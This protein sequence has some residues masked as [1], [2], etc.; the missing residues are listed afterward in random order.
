[1]QIFLTFFKNQ[2]LATLMS[3]QCIQS[4]ALLYAKRLEKVLFL[5]LG[6]E[7]IGREQKI[8]DYCYMKG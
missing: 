1:M 7:F 4:Y 3:A 8:K 5:L 6:E 2:S